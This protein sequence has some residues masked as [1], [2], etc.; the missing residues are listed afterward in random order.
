MIRRRFVLHA[1]SVT[2]LAMSGGVAFGEGPARRPDPKNF[3]SGDFLWPKIPGQFIPYNNAIQLNASDEREQWQTEKEEFLG[4]R[5]VTDDNPAL[6]RNLSSLTYDEFRLLYL[7]DINE[8]EIVPYSLGAFAAVGHVAIVNAPNGGGHTVVDA[9]FGDGVLEQTYDQ[10]LA[11]RPN[12]IVWHGRLKD[13]TDSQR[14]SIVTLAQSQ[15]GK[16]YDFWNFDLMDTSGFYCSKLAWWATMASIGIALDNNPKSKRAFWFSP[17][18][19]LNSPRITKL[20]DPGVYA[21]D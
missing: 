7:R 18:Q 3:R 8:G 16:P 9:N 4:S 12:S 21:V 15:V 13:T 5:E 1:L 6:V 11:R 17:K 10:W 20:T 19:M 14:R 2:I